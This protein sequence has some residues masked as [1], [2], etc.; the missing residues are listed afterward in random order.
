RE[1]SSFQDI[2]QALLFSK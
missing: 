2:I 1:T